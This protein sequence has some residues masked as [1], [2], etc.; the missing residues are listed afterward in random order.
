M[1]P[2]YSIPR[3]KQM[4]FD[5]KQGGAYQSSPKLAPLLSFTKACNLTPTSTPFRTI[6]PWDTKSGDFLYSQIDNKRFKKSFSRERMKKVKQCFISK[7][8]QNK[9]EK[10]Q[11]NS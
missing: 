6:I 9:I 3:Q 7:N 10:K 5:P 1:N 11:K 2:L 4:N 8:F